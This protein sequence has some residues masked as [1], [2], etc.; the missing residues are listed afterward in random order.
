MDRI[1]DSDQDRTGD[2]LGEIDVSTQR[3]S[4]VEAE[5]EVSPMLQG[6]DLGMSDREDEHSPPKFELISEYRISHPSAPTNNPPH[7][8]PPPLAKDISSVRFRPVLVMA[9]A[10]MT[11][12]YGH[13]RLNWPEMAKVNIATNETSFTYLRLSMFLPPIFIPEDNSS[14]SARLI[15]SSA[16]YV[17]ENRRE[18]ASLSHPFSNRKNFRLA[19]SIR[20]VASC[21]S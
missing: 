9:Q 20:I 15:T 8:P 2:R 10:E 6:Y 14:I 19:V 12:T 1:E 11:S 18:Y 16:Y 13:P 5:I 21:L 7:P 4:E 3:V 17:E